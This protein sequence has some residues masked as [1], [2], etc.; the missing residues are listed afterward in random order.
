MCSARQQ[1]HTEKVKIGSCCA[2]E[3]R[4]RRCIIF[5]LF[6]A[7]ELSSTENR[8]RRKEKASSVGRR[9][10]SER[11]RKM[12]TSFP[13]KRVISMSCGEMF[14]WYCATENTNRV[15][16]WLLCWLPCSEKQSDWSACS[17]AST[18]RTRKKVCSTPLTTLHLLWLF[19]HPPIPMSLVIVAGISHL[20]IGSEQRKYSG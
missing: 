17:S 10:D 14:S 9:K 5:H 7:I 18:K 8:G 4:T 12:C 15:F 2:L 20:V 3:I 11:A 13:S 19:I 6:Y 1:E 16:C